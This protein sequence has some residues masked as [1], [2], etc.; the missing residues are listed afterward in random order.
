MIAVLDGM[1]VNFTY[2]LELL[3]S[4]TISFLR[5][6]APN[7]LVSQG[8][9]RRVVTITDNTPP[10]AEVTHPYYDIHPYKPPR[11]RVVPTPPLFGGDR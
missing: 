7:H 9:G 2:R 3:S 6:R 1:C 10:V 5:L 4:I 11:G 8:N